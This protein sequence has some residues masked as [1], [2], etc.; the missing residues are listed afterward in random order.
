MNHLNF[1]LTILDFRSPK[2]QIADLESKIVCLLCLMSYA[3]PVAA[4]WELPSYA[5]GVVI[6]KFSSDDRSEIDAF[7]NRSGVYS[8]ERAFPIVQSPQRLSAIYKLEFSPGIDIASLVRQYENDPVVEYAQPNYLN[9]LCS[10]D[11]A[12][13][14]PTAEPNDLFY[15]DQ[16]ALQAIDAPEAWKIEKGSRDVVIAIVD[17]GVNYNHEDLK[18]RIWTNEEES[19]GN[20]VDDD[21]NGYVDDIRGWDF[22]DSPYLPSDVDH[23]DR[24]NDPMDENGHGTHVAGVVAAVPDNSTGIAG[25]TWNCRIMAL[26]GGGDF[27]EDDDL[28]AAIVYAADNGARVINMSWGGEDLSYIIRDAI[29]YAYSRGCVLVGAVGNDNRPSVI[30]PALHKHVIAVGATDKWDKKAYFSNYGPGV[31]I[32][33]PGDRVFGT[34]LNGKYSDWSGTSMATPVVCGVAALMISKRPGLTSEE[35]N[36][37]L[38]YSADEVD[39]PLFAGVG[40]VNAAEALATASSPL[41]ARITSPDS[42][43]GADTSLTIRGTAAGSHFLRFQLEYSL[44]D[45]LR[46]TFDDVDWKP[47]GCPQNTRMFDDTLGDWNVAHLDEGTHVVKLRVFGD[48]GLETEDRVI[49]NIDHSTP[50][51]TELRVVPRLE[52]DTCRYTVTWRTDDL[53]SG[54]LHYRAKDEEFQKVASSSVT[55]EHVIYISDEVD[56][57]NYEYFVTATN[58]AELVTVDDN[59]GDY[60]PLEVKLLRITSDGFLETD[61]DIPAIHPVSGTADLDGD[62]RT[63]IVGMCTKWDYDTVKIYEAN[64][65]SG[66]YD[67][68]FASDADYFPWDVADTDA[69]GLFEILG[70]KKDMTYLYE[71]PSDGSYPTEKIWEMKGIWGGQIADMDLDG[72]REIVSRHLDTGDIVI[73]ENRGDNS[74]LKA[75]RLR[76]PTE[77]GNY[78]ATTFAISDLDGDGRTEIAAGDWDGDLF[79][80]ENTADDKYSHTWTGSVPHSHIKYVKAGDFDGDGKDELVV[81]AR[82]TEPYTRLDRRWIYTIFDERPGEDKY[83]AVW[84]QEIMGEKSS[85]SGVS[86]GDLDNDGR[87]EIAILV[88]P[89][90]YILKYGGTGITARD[91]VYEPIWYHSAT[92]TRWP[93]VADLDADGANDIL[94]NDGDKLTTFKWSPAAGV[95]IHRPWGLS[96]TPLGESEVELRWNGPPDA[97]SY[98]IYRGADEE[99]LHLVAFLDLSVPTQILPLTEG[100]T[101]SGYFRDAGLETGVTYWYSVTSVNAAGQESDRSHKASATPNSPPQLLSA[102]YMSPFTVHLNFTETMGPSAQDEACY[103]ITSV[104][105]RHAVSLL[106]VSPSSAILDSQGKR[107]IVTVERGASLL[108][109]NHPA[110][111]SKDS[112][113]D[114]LPQGTYTITVSGVRDATGVPIS[115]DSSSA[116]FH[117]PAPDVRDWLDLS[118]MVVYPNPVMP[119]SRHPGRITFDNLP[120]ASTIRIYN[121][122]GQFI[123]TLDG[124]ESGRSREFWYLDNDQQQDVASGIY[125]YIVECTGDRKVGKL[126]VVR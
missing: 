17:T 24:D 114:G 66:G 22:A 13:R 106:K 68:V 25:V 98:R 124:T 112:L 70:S 5:P 51:I 118:R 49:L 86:A 73:Y 37:I 108:V 82:A 53:T 12:C 67:E 8:A 75:A 60:Y 42:G 21:G 59:N 72:Q 100:G 10:G 78:L 62:G 103:T 48:D 109:Q 30:Y 34:T 77:G 52:G 79:I 33:A 64:D 20:G 74:Y 58:L 116:T 18:S 121:Y 87:D 107:V 111:G 126:A 97:R 50:E 110:A 38:R 26:R 65:E 101:A 4:E 61:I 40:R 113:L 45:V 85:E 89:N 119:N 76:N 93:I 39:E 88:T 2:S 6:V 63:E 28:S 120:P 117:V 99:H 32:F 29:E 27:L 56:P 11:T 90:F 43:A 96:A 122:N 80:Y 84:S 35:V 31:D 15:Q 123:R 57:G 115:T 41:I 71:S 44:T 55:D 54:E 3:L 94:F 83:E 16:W 125:I 92:N 46:L 102:E 23:L 7:L 69:D 81:G 19:D 105:T 14:I 36:Q 104:E 91:R 9:H 1:R 47:I 95:P